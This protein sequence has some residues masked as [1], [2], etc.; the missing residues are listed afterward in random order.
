MM[1]A[2]SR[3]VFI[4]VYLYVYI[5]WWY[6]SESAHSSYK[7]KSSQ[8]PL[9]TACLRTCGDRPLHECRRV[10]RLQPVARQ[11]QRPQLFPFVRLVRRWCLLLISVC[12]VMGGGGVLKCL[13]SQPPHVSTHVCTQTLTPFMAAKSAWGL[14]P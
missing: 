5:R 1:L 8:H 13:G 4:C 12:D 7:G 11:R 14:V 9:P 6:V 3:P 10:A 2:A